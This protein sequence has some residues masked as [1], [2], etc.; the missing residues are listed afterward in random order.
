MLRFRLRDLFSHRNAS[1]ACTF[2]TKA[3]H[4]RSNSS[5][6]RVRVVVVVVVGLV[7]VVLVFEVLEGLVPFSELT[8]R[9]SL[10]YL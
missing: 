8:D 4:R 6:R 7:D 3:E 5:S 1:R 2:G 10:R 9:R